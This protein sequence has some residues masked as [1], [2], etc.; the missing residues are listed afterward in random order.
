MQNIESVMGEAMYVGR[1]G[2]YG[3]S[4]PSFQFCCELKTALKKK[5][6]HTCTTETKKKKLWSD[7]AIRNWVLIHSFNKSLLSAHCV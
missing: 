7:Q 1:Q 4:L 3:K 5:K 6:S 2:A